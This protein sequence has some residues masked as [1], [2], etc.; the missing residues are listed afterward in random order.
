MQKKNW[1]L[2]LCEHSAACYPVFQPFIWKHIIHI[3]TS[4]SNYVLCLV[5]TFLLNIPSFCHLNHLA[6][7]WFILS[8]PASLLKNLQIQLLPQHFHFFFP[9]GIPIYPAYRKLNLPLTFENLNLT[10]YSIVENSGI[11]L[12]IFSQS[13]KLREYQVELGLQVLC[14]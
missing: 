10:P 13:R 3:V 14:V 6:T 12:H 7:S 4:L 1:V 5:S 2:T 8:A 9:V 11:S